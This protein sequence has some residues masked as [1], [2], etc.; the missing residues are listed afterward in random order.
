[1]AV[2]VRDA[3]TPI[4]G[5]AVAAPPGI[6]VALTSLLGPLREAMRATALPAGTRLGVMSS[7][8]LGWVDAEGRP[9]D[10]NGGK[11]LRGCL[12]L[13]AAQRCGGEPADAIGVATAVEW[14][15]NFTLVHDDIQDGDTERRHRPTVWAV[16]GRAQAINAGDGMHAAAYRT[17]LAGRDHPDRRLRSAAVLNDA[18]LAVI[19]GQCLDLDLEGHVD[20]AVST[21]LRLARAKTGALMGAS[22]EAGAVMG[23]AGTRRASALGR[24]GC[25]LGLAFQV[26]DDWL[27]VWG[28]SVTTG[29][30]SGGDLQRR[31]VT[32]PVVVARSRLRGAAR[33]ELRRLYDHRGGDEAAI[34]GLL[35]E[36]GA[37]D[38][39]AEELTRRGESALHLVEA[40]GLPGETVEEFASIIDF[41]VNRDA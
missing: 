19:E 24:A 11:L 1:M 39:V 3:S 15:H 22:L 10:D 9:R 8:H 33:R 32:Y 21:Y 29:K 27:G 41:V 25:E 26:R 14:I 13:W 30:G 31:K 16:W 6:P 7:Y 5:S 17:L 4:A 40:S 2:A 20:T 28:D 35:E 23:G 37:R 12:A 34:R 36:G 18:A 38:V